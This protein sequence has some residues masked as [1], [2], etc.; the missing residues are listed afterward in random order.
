MHWVSVQI[1]TIIWCAEKWWMSRNDIRQWHCWRGWLFRIQIYRCHCSS[2]GK[3]C[4]RWHNCCLAHSM[5]VARIHICRYY[6][7]RLYS[8]NY[9]W[10]FEL[11][12]ALVAFVVAH[13]FVIVANESVLCDS[14][15]RWLV[16]S[17][18][19]VEVKMMMADAMKWI[20]KIKGWKSE[21]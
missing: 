11:R 6:V 17:M 9:M 10:T 1:P 5:C 16:L 2:H 21:K 19:V 3:Y 7:M 20:Y 13:L 4:V 12:R 18:A 14:A 8:P 15:K